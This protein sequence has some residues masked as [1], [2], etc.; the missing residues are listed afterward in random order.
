MLGSQ[1]VVGV[2]L[3]TRVG[4]HGGR[5]I[6]LLSVF[7]HKKYAQNYNLYLSIS[8]NKFLHFLYRS[9]LF[10]TMA[11]KISH[12]HFVYV[13][14]MS[15]LIFQTFDRMIFG[16]LGYSGPRRYVVKV[17]DPQILRYQEK[18]GNQCSNSS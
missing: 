15:I 11:I 7:L 6:S 14:F 17:P 13:A 8:V 4:P 16:R 2:P 12:S 18:F 1:V 5:R 9:C 10:S 3:V